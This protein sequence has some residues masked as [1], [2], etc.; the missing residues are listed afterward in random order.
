MFS[1]ATKN[2][3]ELFGPKRL[4][5]LRAYANRKKTGENRTL[6]AV[7]T[8]DG[9][10]WAQAALQVGQSSRIIW[11]RCTL[12]SPTYPKQLL[13][14]TLASLNQMSW[15]FL[16]THL[17]WNQ[18]FSPRRFFF[19]ASSEKFWCKRIRLKWCQKVH[20]HKVYRKFYAKKWNKKNVSRNL[21]GIR[22]YGFKTAIQNR[23][24][25]NMPGGR[26]Y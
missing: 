26:A 17:K 18:N 15:N 4:P 5:A 12:S 13:E 7:R 11:Q 24:V 21:A 2:A 1:S 23:G 8:G 20:L 9:L 6:D 16:W 22:I 14:I 10:A 19:D 3:P 25:A